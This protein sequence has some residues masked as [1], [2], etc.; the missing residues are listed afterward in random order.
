MRLLTLKDIPA[1]WCEK[2]TPNNDAVDNVLN[3][4]NTETNGSIN[5][6]VRERYVRTVY[7]HVPLQYAMS[8]PVVASYDELARCAQWMGG[9]IP[10]M[11]EARSIYHYVNRMKMEFQ[12]SFGSKTPAVNGHL[13]NN[14][15]DETPPSRPESNGHSSTSTD[16][17]PQ[18]TFID[19]GGTNVGFKHWHPVSVVERGGELCGQ[20]DLGGVWEWTSSVLEKHGGFVPMEIYPG[21][22]ADFFDGKHNIVLG[23]SWATHPRI[24]GRKTFINWYQRNYPYVWAGARIVTN[25]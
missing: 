19:L 15:V 13:I 22:T 9:R 14:G 16:F 10:T 6:K 23:G 20:S 1:S 25:I 7:G 18:D 24:A 17:N 12:Q 4:H 2:L 21:Y 5:H 3:E 8:W 11:D